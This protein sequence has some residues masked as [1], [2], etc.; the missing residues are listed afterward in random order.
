M[1]YATQPEG[2][3]GGVLGTT[4]WVL[5]LAGGSEGQLEG[6][7]AQL[8]GSEG[9]L[10]GLRAS[11]GGTDERKDGKAPH[12]TEDFVPYRGCCPKSD[13]DQFN[14]FWKSF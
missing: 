9:Q 13:R 12:S 14:W 7:E 8:E 2:L 11:Q 5:G 3:T 1:R 10:E 6:P 4:R